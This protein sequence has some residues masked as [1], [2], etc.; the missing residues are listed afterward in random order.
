MEKR[1]LV[2]SNREQIL[3]AIGFVDA[4]IDELL[5]NITNGKGL[6]EGPKQVFTSRCVITK[7]L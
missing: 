4:F 7:T 6:D 2:K 5:K 1:E 3:I